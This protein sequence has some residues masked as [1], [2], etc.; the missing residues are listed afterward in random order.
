MGSKQNS[1]L[2]SEETISRYHKQEFA[3][4]M[5]KVFLT[6]CYVFGIAYRF[7][8]KFSLTTIFPLGISVAKR[9]LDDLTGMSLCR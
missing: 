2:Q 4:K 8:F 7:Y 3:D 9:R 1:E 5:L 6:L